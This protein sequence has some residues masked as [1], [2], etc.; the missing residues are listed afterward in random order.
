MQQALRPHPEAPI[1][2]AVAAHVERALTDYLA[3]RHADM[4]EAAPSFGTAVASLAGFVLGGGKRLR[5][6][7]AW[8]GWRGAGG[9]GAGVDA[10]AV[11]RGVSALELIQACALVHDDLMDASAMRRGKPTVH[12][13]FAARHREAGWLGEPDRFGAATAILLGDLALAWADDM[14]ATSGLDAGRLAAALPPWQAMRAEML[15]GQYLDVL[16]QARGDESEA[17]A[18][19]VARMKTAAYTVERPL[20]LG[21]ALA[22]AP[23][24]TVAAL[25][26]FG[27]DI[28][29]AFQ[30]R[31]D[32]L[33]MYGDTEVTGKPAGD[34]LREGKRTLLMALGMAMAGDRAAVLRAAL[35]ADDLSPTTLADVRGILVEVG[36]V[37]EVERRI[38]ALTAT[39][40]AALDRADLAG[41]ADRVLAE[42]AVA[43]GR[44]TS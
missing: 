20:H 42:L 17:T 13:D 10:R 7:F 44:R 15:A 27:A 21:A 1:D 32:L 14:F 38:D 31:D 22:G 8:W 2:D 40:L 28:G 34:D 24:P 19:S 25:R 33:G 41:P 12:M 39:A 26:A 37:A 23:A 11:L 5:P 29:L 9:A 18:L 36:A 43:A 3:T 30:L 16:T 35:G 4:A 6:T